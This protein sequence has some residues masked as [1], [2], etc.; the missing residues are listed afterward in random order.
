MWNETKFP[1]GKD[2]IIFSACSVNFLVF[3]DSYVIWFETTAIILEIKI[4]S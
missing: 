1:F 4:N 2:K 3:L